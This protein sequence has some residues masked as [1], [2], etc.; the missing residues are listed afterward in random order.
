[1]GTSRSGITRYLSL[2]DRHVLLSR[3]SSRLIHIG[4]RVVFQRNSTRSPSTNSQEG[5]WGAGAP[6]PGSPWG[7]FT[8]P[9]GS[10]RA[11][12][13][14]GSVTGGGKGPGGAGGAWRGEQWPPLSTP[15]G[16]L[17][18]PI[19]LQNVGPVADTRV[20]CPSGQVTNNLHLDGGQER[21]RGN[22]TESPKDPSKGGAFVHNA[23]RGRGAG[24]P[25]LM[26]APARMDVQAKRL[27]WVGPETGLPWLHPG[28]SAGHRAPPPPSASGP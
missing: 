22:V 4:T 24:L 14:P 3:M 26:C 11:Q 16:N 6:S 17:S 23:G 7:T 12:A 8:D 25:D 1:M 10:R 21:V 15:V 20:A 18:V 2:C 27:R 19:S 13:A 28:A 5:S 9:Q